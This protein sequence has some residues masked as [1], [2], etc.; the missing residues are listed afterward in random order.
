MK[1]IKTF[2]NRWYILIGILIFAYILIYK[3]N[4]REIAKI[5]KK[6]NLNLVILATL[7]T[8]V[9]VI[10]HSYRW[11]YLKRVQNINYTL[12]DSFL[13]YHAAFLFS[14]I[15]PGRIGD[16]LK[17]VYLKRDGHSVGKSL[18]NVVVDRLADI[19]LLL[20]VGYISMCFFAR[21]FLNYIIIF[22][23]LVLAALFLIFLIKKRELPKIIARKIIKFIVPEKHQKSWHLNYQDFINGIK[24]YKFKNYLMLFL[25]TI[26][27]WIISYA[28]TFLLAKSIEINISFIYLV[29]SITI[30]TLA[31]LIPI[32]ILGLGTR[33]AALIFLFSLFAIA[34]EKAISLSVLYLSQLLIIAFIGLMSWIK[35]PLPLLNSENLQP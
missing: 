25:L 21:F 15:T 10:I 6:T 14:T 27:M 11:N 5:I 12:K 29:M 24:A 30:A 22:S 8:L 33:D 9:T 32:S 1:I 20:I 23:I 31:T 28:S 3:T 13:M 7:L 18:L 4:I 19:F 34:P 26:A 35:K 2:K 17:V 16:L